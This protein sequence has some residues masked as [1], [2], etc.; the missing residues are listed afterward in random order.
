VKDT[1]SVADRAALGSQRDELAR[2]YP[3]PW[4]ALLF[5]LESRGKKPAAQKGYQREVLARYERNNPDEIASNLDDLAKAVSRRKNVGLYLPPGVLALDLEHSRAIA[6]VNQLLLDV[7]V[8][9]QLSRQDLAPGR[10]HA[11]F[12]VEREREVPVWIY[13][14]AQSEAEATLVKRPAKGFIVVAPSTHPKTG[15]LYRWSTPLPRSPGLLPLVS[16][17]F[18]ANVAKTPPSA[19]GGRTGRGAVNGCDMLWW[20]DVRRANGGR[21]PEGLR[22][23]YLRYVAWRARA[24]EGL[25]KNGIRARLIEA[26]EHDVES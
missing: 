21:V 13:L 2:T 19:S 7:P 8:P 1:P 3:G 24:V 17:E 9:R 25:D 26:R 4:G 16:P 6:L 18:L 14:D 23:D 10:G 5:P 15:E 22:H 20:R 12:R 11:L